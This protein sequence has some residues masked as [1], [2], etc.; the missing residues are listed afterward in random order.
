M[1]VITLIATY[2]DLGLTEAIQY[3]LPHYFINKEYSKA[4]SILV[5]TLISQFISSF[6][7]IAILLIVAPRLATHYFHTPLALPLL[8]IFCIC[9][10]ILN[11]F[12][13]VQSLFIATQKVKW[14]Q[15]I[16]SIRM[17]SIVAF[18][19]IGWQFHILTVR[20]FTRYRLAGLILAAII[21]LFAIRKEFGWLRGYK[22][23]I[24]TK[25]IKQRFGYALWI[26]I[27]TNASIII[28]QIDQQFALYFFGSETAGYRTNYLTLF[29][30]IM[31]IGSPLITYLFPLLN[32]LNKKNER[33]KIRLLNRL[34]YAGFFAFG[35]LVGVIAYFW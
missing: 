6:L 3:F 13:V 33:Q 5:F 2:N 30:G 9:F 20:T 19:I 22:T 17:R 18:V 12:Q 11:I 21:G 25:M 27:G 26:I 23:H 31:I 16:E 35:L 15:G 24:D 34:L 1:G 8:Q 28:S 29:N 32:E 7:I 4:K 10:L 14:S